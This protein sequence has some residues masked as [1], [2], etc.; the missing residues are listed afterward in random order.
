MHFGHP[1]LLLLELLVPVLIAFY[2][3]AFYREK[4]LLEKFGQPALLQRLSSAHGMRKKIKAG[5]LAGSLFFLILSAARPQFGMRLVD[6]KQQ[7]ADVVIA[8][9]VS[10]SMLAEDLKPNRLEKAKT[11]LSRLIQQL[12]GNRVGI[13][14][15]AGNAF[16]QCP[17]TFDISS[18]NL[19]LQI[20]DANLIPLP[21][22]AIGSALRLGVQG[23]SKTAPKS[24][25]IILLTDGEDHKSDPEGAADEAAKQGVK[26]YA[27]GFGNP[28]GEPIPV[29]DD[30]GNFSGYKKDKKGTVVMSKLDEALLTRITS[31]TGGE[32]FRAQ[33]GDIEVNRLVDEVNGLE[34]QKLASRHYQQY[35]DRYQYFLA[36]GLLLLLIEFIIPAGKVV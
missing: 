2:L 28:A 1:Y 36:L 12:G 25:A 34:K 10:N 23:L 6:V 17:L 22:T 21:G 29:R 8:V 35:E 26:I 9:D 3:Y 19:F 7:G 27:I 11:L 20:M 14:A 24:K 5:L 13:I 30:K 31:V 15:F 16:W 33:D 32:Y 18:A 4:K